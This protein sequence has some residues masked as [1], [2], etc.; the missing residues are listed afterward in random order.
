M[1]PRRIWQPQAGTIVTFK[2]TAADERDLLPW[3]R[4][5]RLRE[6]EVS[7]FLRSLLRAAMR[8][9]PEWRGSAGGGQSGTEAAGA[10]RSPSPA[11]APEAAP[12]PAEPPSLPGA[13]G[14]SP[15]GQE[16]LLGS[17]TAEVADQVAQR[18][19]AH[20]RQALAPGAG[21]P[22]PLAGGGEMVPVTGLWIDP[23]GGRLSDTADQSLRALDDLL[24][25][26]ADADEELDAEA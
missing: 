10:A 8:S 23:D 7:A 26:F 6:G 3:L 24:D 15:T 2:L 13:A 25:Q 14:G 21:A 12:D 5:R 20:L 4:S 11:A 22:G 1:A 18:V 19:L 16:K 17:W 9:D